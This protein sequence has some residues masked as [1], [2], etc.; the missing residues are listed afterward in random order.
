MSVSN[1]GYYFKPPSIDIKSIISLSPLPNINGRQ[2]LFGCSIDLIG[3]LPSDE[4]RFGIRVTDSANHTAQCNVTILAAA[5]HILGA[6]TWSSDAYTANVTEN[7]PENTPVVQVSAAPAAVL[8]DSE[9]SPPE[10]PFT[11]G[12][13]I[14]DAN[15]Y[16]KINETSGE[17]TCTELGIDRDAIVQNRVLGQNAIYVQAY[18]RFN[19][20]VQVFL[21]IFFYFYVIHIIKK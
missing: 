5:N 21:L 13:Q 20:T 10:V 18:M 6:L 1:N 14:V 8:I 4:L 9:S 17:I 3:D 16:Y 12:Y 15:G 11:I 7:S 19:A 2:S